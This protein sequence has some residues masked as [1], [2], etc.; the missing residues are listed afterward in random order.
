MKT[1]NV[2]LNKLLSYYP[3]IYLNIDDKIPYDTINYAKVTKWVTVGGGL[4]FDCYDDDIQCF[5]TLDI[6]LTELQTYIDQIKRD[7][8][9]KVLIEIIN[10]DRL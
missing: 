5:V 2:D 3:Y 10:D 1:I 9:L 4:V 8:K 7:E 6:S